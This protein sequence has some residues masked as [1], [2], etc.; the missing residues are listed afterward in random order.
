[1]TFWIP[2]TINLL[3]ATV[4]VF[5]FL[6][7][8]ADG[9][10]SSFNL[11]L[12]LLILCAAVV[13][14]GGSLALRAAAHVKSAQALVTVFAVPGVLVGLFFAVILLVPGRWN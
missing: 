14:V 4:L 5:F 7:G 8:L 9:S 2:W 10:I 6:L 11:A 3:M 12:W 1:M 13:V